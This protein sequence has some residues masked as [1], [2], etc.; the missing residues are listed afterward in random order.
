MKLRKATASAAPAIGQFE[1]PQKNRKRWY[2]TV[3]R[4]VHGAAARVEQ[5]YEEANLLPLAKEQ[6]RP[7]PLI[8]GTADKNVYLPHT[9]RPAAALVR[10]GRD[11]EVQ[12]LPGVT[13]VI[14]RDPVAERVWARTAAF[15]KRHLG[16]RGDPG[17]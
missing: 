9:L 15:F 17:A 7:L 13:H 8:H 12:P 4:A 16:G 14:G 3:H 5:A 6:Q 10:A 1:A 11:F 2:T